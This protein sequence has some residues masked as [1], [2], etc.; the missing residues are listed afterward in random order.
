MLF[1]DMNPQMMYVEQ[2]GKQVIL[3]NEAQVQGQNQFRFSFEKFVDLFR[4]NKSQSVC[5]GCECY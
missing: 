4:T 2:Q 1:H 3:A 5:C